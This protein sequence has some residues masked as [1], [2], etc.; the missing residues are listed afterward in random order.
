MKKIILP[1]TA[2]SRRGRSDSFGFHNDSVMLR[3]EKDEA[4]RQYQ[5]Y[6]ASEKRKMTDEEIYR[7]EHCEAPWLCLGVCSEEIERGDLK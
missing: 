1:Q 2:F 3:I 5:K 6:L 7:C 4:E